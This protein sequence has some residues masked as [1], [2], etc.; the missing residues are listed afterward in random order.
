VSHHPVSTQGATSSVAPVMMFSKWVSILTLFQH[1]VQH[2]YPLAWRKDDGF[3]PH[4]VSTQG[5]TSDRIALT[6]T[7]GAFQSSPCFNT[8]CNG[9]IDAETA[10]RLYVSILT[11]FQHRVQRSCL[12]KS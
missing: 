11:L 3:N 6:W 2:R 4:P 8:G 5:A 7:P 12:A 10:L 1:R 9:L